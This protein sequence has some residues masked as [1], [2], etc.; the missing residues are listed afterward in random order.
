M[1]TILSGKIHSFFFFN[2]KSLIG[3]KLVLLHLINNSFGVTPNV[4]IFLVDDLGYGDLGC[5]GNST[6]NTFNID[7]LARDGVRY[8]QMYSGASMCTPSRGS[9]LT[10]RYAI[11][12]G[13]SSNDNRFR[14]FNSPAQSGGLPHDEIT[15]A[16]S[17]WQLGYRTGLIGKWHLGIGR[18]AEHLP[19]YHGFDTF[20]GMPVTNVQTCG[21]KKVFNLIGSRGESIDRSFVFY[22]IQMTGKVQ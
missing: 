11:R 4:L 13:L 12:L 18:G 21:N 15:M 14:T 9:L 6:I 16:E 1:T 17:A 7:T 3:I 19:I 8:T 22:W 5:Y 10:G 20:F 2:M